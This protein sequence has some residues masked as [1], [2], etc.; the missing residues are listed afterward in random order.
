MATATVE[1]LSEIVRPDGLVTSNKKF[2]EAIDSLNLRGKW[3]Q[4]EQLAEL[5]IK[6]GRAAD[7]RVARNNW[8][9]RALRDNLE[10]EPLLAV[11]ELSK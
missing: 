6:S 2:W 11:A 4:C 3:H 9:L 10:L 1:T 8:F 7:Y 5:D